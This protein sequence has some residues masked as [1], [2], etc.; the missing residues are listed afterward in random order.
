MIESDHYFTAQP[1]S[2]AEQR[3][4]RVTL[5][6]REVTVRVASGIFSPGGLDRGTAVLL[7]EVPDPPQHGDL[8]DLGCGWGPIALTLGLLS[9]D[10]TV[11]AVDVNERA[12]DLARANARALGLR[13]VRASQPD[14][15]P[16]GQRFD[17]IWSNPPI[18]IGKQALHDLLMAWLPR[19]RPGGVAYLVVQKNLGADSLQRW[20]GQQLPQES[21][22]VGRLAT[23]KGFRVLAVTRLGN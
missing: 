19:L 18:R 11:W 12:L 15:I 2:S 4:L 21:Y 20:L 7:A 16:A 1:A 8:L 10:A 9:P 13:D 22:A 14:G 6:G 23:S 3:D 17:C 5:A